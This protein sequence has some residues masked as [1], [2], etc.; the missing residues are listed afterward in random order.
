MEWIIK[1]NKMTYLETVS[2]SVYELM[3]KYSN[4]IYLGE[5]VRNG[6]RGITENFIKKFGKKRIIDTPISEASF[7]ALLLDW[8]FRV[9]G[10]LWSLILLV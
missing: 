9:I 10:R 2:K 4:T 5:D 8:L 3:D 7:A 1:K 6:Q